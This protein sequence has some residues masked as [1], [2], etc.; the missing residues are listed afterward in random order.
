MLAFVL[1]V[2]SQI[3]NDRASA[4][5]IAKGLHIIS[6]FSVVLLLIWMYFYKTKPVLCKPAFPAMFL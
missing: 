3:P 1:L 4:G 2:I 5:L 6:Y